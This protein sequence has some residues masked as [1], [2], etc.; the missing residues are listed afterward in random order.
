LTVAQNF[1]ALNQ[2]GPALFDRRTPK[3]LLIEY[4]AVSAR[5]WTKDRTTGARGP[6]GG[7]GPN[8]AVLG[9]GCV[10]PAVAI[11]PYG[12]LVHL[13]TSWQLQTRGKLVW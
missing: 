8:R 2:P 3:A 10:P 5:G 9:I 11:D 13:F 7:D 12:N 6:G 1:A 4:G